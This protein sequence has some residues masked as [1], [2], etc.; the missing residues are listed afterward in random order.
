MDRLWLL[1][2]PCRKTM[3]RKSLNLTAVLLECSQLSSHC[4]DQILKFRTRTPLAQR[5]SSSCSV[6]MYKVKARD[7]WARLYSSDS[8]DVIPEILESKASKEI[9]NASLRTWRA[10]KTKHAGRWFDRRL[11]TVI[12]LIN[13][14]AKGSGTFWVTS[15]ELLVAF[16]LPF[17]ISQCIAPGPSLALPYVKLTKPC[18]QAW[19]YRRMLLFGG[20]KSRWKRCEDKMANRNKK[21]I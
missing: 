19:M 16:Q 6:V 11:F 21:R 1:V 2:R 12:F 15:V 13:E 14:P 8:S 9:T 5:A 17:G 4:R 3:S 10:R 7:S 20:P 18:S